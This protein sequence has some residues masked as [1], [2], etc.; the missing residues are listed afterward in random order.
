[1][2]AP[3]PVKT[4]LLAA[5]IA[6]TVACG[7]SSKMTP[8]V[9]GSMPA[10]AQLAPN[11]ASAG[12]AFTLTVN[13]SNF[14]SHAVVNFNGTAQTTTFV[15]ANQLTASIPAKAVTTAGTA[16]VTV[17]NPAISG[18]GMYGSGGTLAETSMSMNFTIN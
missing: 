6:L 8:A 13:G 14:A 17:T 2:K 4:I 15:S 3:K 7:Y 10:I 9:A 18:T 1:M 16:S 11:S 5:L 12:T